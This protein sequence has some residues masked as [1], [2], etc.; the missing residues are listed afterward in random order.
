VSDRKIKLLLFL[1]ILVVCA[2]PLAAA[3][4]LVDDALQRSLNLGFNPQVVRSMDIS[5]QNLKTLKSLDPGHGREYREE[6]EEL[7]D[8]KRIYSQPQWVKSTILGSLKIY[9]GLGLAGAVLV[10]LSVAVI[11][12]RRISRSYRVTF[13]DL[14]AHRERVRYL[15]E[16]AS[17]QE[18]AKVLA[19]EIKNP[20]TPIEVLVTSLAKS[21]LIKTP[22]EFQAQL[23]QTQVMVA[24][25]IGHLK[26]TVSRF[27]D[28]A[29]LPQV[30][31]IEANPVDVIEQHLAAVR[32]RFGTAQFVVETPED[33]TAIRSRMDFSLFRQVLMNI[34]AN[35]VE[36]N[37]THAVTFA[38]VVIATKDSVVITISNDGEPVPAVIAP[39]IFDPYISSKRDQDNMGLGLAIVKKIIIEH[40]GEIAYAER[41]GQPRFIISLPRVR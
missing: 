18:M 9:F 5:S 38:V 10:A 23:N 17:W 8:L 13:N 15:E 6:F 31:L 37:P 21:H 7:Q 26:R 27:S 33:R 11:L 25:E 12:S 34:V 39:R 41:A 14:M 40:E 29:K 24:E 32:T 2:L 3:F 1:T 35:G 36:A 30:Q 19:H 16:M 4:Y 22:P 28:F 20:L